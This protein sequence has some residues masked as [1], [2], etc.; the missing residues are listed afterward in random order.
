MN[1]LTGQ[2]LGKTN[3]IMDLQEI[4]NRKGD[5]DLTNGEIKTLAAF[6]IQNERKNAN[7][8]YLE[9]GVFA[10]GTT[11]FMIDSTKTSKFIGIDLFEDF[12]ISQDNTHVSGTFRRDDVQTFLGERV[13]LLKGNSTMLLQEL[14]VQ[15]EKFDLI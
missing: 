15:G 6:V 2:F 10:G 12:V 5:S 11:K 7:A 3:N 4:I 9:I 14:K 13:Q 8:K 1:Y